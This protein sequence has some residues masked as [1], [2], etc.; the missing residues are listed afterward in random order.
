M[1]LSIIIPAY[2]AEEYIHKALDSALQQDIFPYE[3]I[4]VDDGSTDATPDILKQYEELHEQVKVLTSKNHGPAM[5]RNLGIKEAQGEYIAFLDS[6]DT[7]QPHKLNHVLDYAKIYDAD[8]VV[9]GFYMQS[10]KANQHYQYSSEKQIINT[11]QSLGE[12][13]ARLYQKSLLNQV[14][15]K[16]F[17]RS[18]L[19]DNGI[20][21]EDYMYGEDRLFVFDVLSHTKTIAVTDECLYNYYIYS[22]G[23]LT[24]RYYDKKFEAII[25][26]AESMQ[27]L[28]G[29]YAVPQLRD[30]QIYAFMFLKSILSCMLSLYD[31]SSP[32]TKKERHAELRR[33]L[34]H[35][36]VRKAVKQGGS[37]GIYFNVS[38]LVIRTEI[39]WVNAMFI[40]VIRFISLKLPRLFLRAKYSAD[41]HM[42]VYQP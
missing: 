5:A 16:L 35:E 37:F 38:R 8:L 23:S 27:R 15:N 36:D 21:F 11:R 6:D 19:I 41:E 17:R 26:I 29:A 12:E 25:D 2:N 22:T 9:Y 34:K 1:Q 28:S 14:W 40:Q 32:L 4:V 18:L 20:R 3:I 42:T 7:L 24:T 39:M 13:L 10:L 30:E 33:I 31:D